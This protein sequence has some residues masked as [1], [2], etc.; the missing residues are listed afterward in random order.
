[1]S[2]PEYP[3]HP[4]QRAKDFARA[5]KLLDN[6]ERGLATLPCL[7]GLCQI[8]LKWIDHAGAGKGPKP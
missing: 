6:A 1:M 5:Q 2:K 3:Y 4:E 8:A 7:V